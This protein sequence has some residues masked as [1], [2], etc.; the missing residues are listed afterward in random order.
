MCN[1]LFVTN[2]K[3]KKRTKENAVVKIGE[4][5]KL[6]AKSVTNFVTKA[7]Y[8]YKK[9]SFK[10]KEKSSIKWNTIFEIKLSAKSGGT[11]S[12]QDTHTSLTFKA[13]CIITF[14]A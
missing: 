8:Y 14:V 10:G 5:L 4:L 2:Q 13:V 7:C 9:K 3:K 12:V 6:H 11:L 1:E